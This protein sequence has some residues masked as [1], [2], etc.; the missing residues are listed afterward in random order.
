MGSASSKEPA[1]PTNVT[2]ASRS[3]DEMEATE[4]EKQEMKAMIEKSN[5]IRLMV[6]GK[7][8]VG[9]SALL[10][11]IV[12]TKV[13]EEGDNYDPQTLEVDSTT[14]Q[15]A[16]VTITVFD[17]PGLQDGSGNEARYLADMKQKCTN[18]HLLLYCISMAENREDLRIH[19]SAIMKITDHLGKEVWENA[20]IILTFANVFET[21][22]CD[23]GKEGDS[24]KKAFKERLKDWEHHFRL[25]LKA[26]GVSDAVSKNIH[27]YPA[28]FKRPNLICQE[29]WLSNF[30]IESVFAMKED[31]QAAMVKMSIARF[32]EKGDIKPEDFDK[33]ISEQPLVFSK[34]DKALIGTAASG[35]AAAGATAGA[36]IGALAIGIPSFGLAAGL[37]LIL[38]G[39]IGG[40]AGGGT[41]LGAGLILALFRRNKKKKKMV[42]IKK[43]AMEQ[44][45]RELAS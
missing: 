43:K 4:A 29:L 15:K 11:G 23:Q 12:G 26:A 45:G 17:T 6:T 20:V 36:L 5:E 1:A 9:K 33:D 38:G 19:N 44:L 32:R 8:G 28:G 13:F 3:D 14:F 30:W 24:L 35:S 25:A 37:G 41:G 39:A 42:T 21:R 22:L 10:N 18:I 2:N 27:A 16:N 7:T 31:A 40:A 34:L